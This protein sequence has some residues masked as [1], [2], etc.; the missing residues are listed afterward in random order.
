MLNTRLLSWVEHLVSSLDFLSSASG[1]KPFSLLHLPKSWAQEN[2]AIFNYNLLGQFHWSWKGDVHTVFIPEV[3]GWISFLVLDL[4]LGLFSAGG[5]NQ[6]CIF[7]SQLSLGR[8][9]VLFSYVLLFIWIKC[10]MP[11]RFGFDPPLI[12]PLGLNLLLDW[13]LTPLKLHLQLSEEWQKVFSSQGV[14]QRVEA[15]RVVPEMENILFLHSWE[16]SSS[17]LLWLELK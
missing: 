13:L 9:K 12:S 3:C 7:L 2:R 5:A 10:R 8:M 15:V 1:T 14:G 11:H 16:P 6:F 17:H 4:C